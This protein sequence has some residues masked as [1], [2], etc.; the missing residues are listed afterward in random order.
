MRLQHQG[1]PGA[2]HHALAQA[3]TLG[4]R[5]R[6]PVRV[7]R[8]RALQSN[9]HHPLNLHVA[10][11]AQGLAAAHP[12]SLPAATQEPLAPFADR[13]V[14]HSELVRNRSVGTATG[15]FQDNPR[16]LGQRLRAPGPAR[17]TF[18]RLALF[19]PRL[20]GALGLPSAIYST[21]LR[22]R[23]LDLSAFE[24]IAQTAVAHTMRSGRS[25][26]VERACDRIQLQIASTTDRLFTEEV[27]VSRDLMNG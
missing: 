19:I 18:Q 4:Q 12:T 8:G 5:A 3:A 10:H 22:L 20:K 17:P 9:A 23:N 27:L 26:H 11:L 6:A 24:K 2:A 21:P 16:A 7:D 13:L 25:D 15:A 14:G 1:P